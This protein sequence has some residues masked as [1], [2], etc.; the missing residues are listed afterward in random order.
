MTLM[1]IS[2]IFKGETYDGWEL[3]GM[4]HHGY[5]L[6]FGL[7]S[8]RKEAEIKW[9]ELVAVHGW[10]NMSLRIVGLVYS[11]NTRAP[12]TEIENE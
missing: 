6:S 7:F 8:R 10:S 11:P 5:E 2:E 9:A 12:N 4:C 1:R 3:L